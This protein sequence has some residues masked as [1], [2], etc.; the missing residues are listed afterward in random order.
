M[1]NWNYGALY[2]ILAFIIGLLIGRLLKF[3]RN[4]KITDVIIWLLTIIPLLIG[5]WTIILSALLTSIDP[6][7]K[8]SLFA[9]GVALI[10]MAFANIYNYNSAR[11]TKR[12]EEQTKRIEDKLDKVLTGDIRKSLICRIIEV[13]FSKK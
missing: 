1:F 7:L 10:S 2:I 9:V 3:G 4:T 5:V 12:I 6:N 13:L 8:I 11:Q